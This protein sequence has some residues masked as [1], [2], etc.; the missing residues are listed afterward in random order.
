M[1]DHYLRPYL[2]TKPL[3]HT[4]VRMKSLSSCGSYDRLMT[5]PSLTTTRMASTHMCIAN[6][7]LVQTHSTCHHDILLSFKHLFI[8]KYSRVEGTFLA[9]YFS[10]NE[11]LFCCIWQMWFHRK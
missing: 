3:I 4:W 11:V 5:L 9:V 7:V 8:D 2:L 1:S 10:V 6:R